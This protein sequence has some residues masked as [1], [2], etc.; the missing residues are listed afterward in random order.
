[1]PLTPGLASKS[2]YNQK[3]A[4]KSKFTRVS[5]SGKRKPAKFSKVPM[6]MAAISAS[7]NA[8]NS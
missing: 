8:A 1:M 2:Q 6:N 5:P 7:L 3:P 4:P